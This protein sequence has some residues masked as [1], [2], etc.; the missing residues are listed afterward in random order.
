MKRSMLNFIV[1]LVVLAASGFGLILAQDEPGT[2]DARGYEDWRYE[3]ETDPTLQL[4]EPNAEV[5]RVVDGD[6]FE[7]RYLDDDREWKVRILGIDTP[8]T[9]DP[10]KPVECFGKE[11]S[12][13]MTDL[14]EGT[15]I[16]LDEDPEADEVDR[17]GRLLRNVILTDG[18]DV[19]ALMV[20]E[21]YAHALTSFPLNAERKVELRE[22]ERQAQENEVGLWSPDACANT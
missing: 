9:V 14:I 21:G 6:T 8:E 18:T 16:R 7:A 17:Y 3:I 15:R 19:G 4:V 20:S 12:Q 10:R 1:V 5:L 2:P 22:L 13:K 11:A